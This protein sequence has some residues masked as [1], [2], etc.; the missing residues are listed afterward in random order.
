MSLAVWAS[1]NS[2]LRLVKVKTKLEKAW[3]GEASW[4]RLLRPLSLIFGWVSQSRR[5]RDQRQAQ[6]AKVP[7][8]VVG[9]ISV[10][11][12]GKTP[13]LIA[14]IRLC[15]QEGLRVGVISRGYG[16]VADNY[17]LSVTHATDPALCGDEP[18]MIVR[19]T[20]VSL[21]VDP[22]RVSAVNALLALEPLDL[23]LSD[24]G[25]QHYR[26]A[27]QLEIAVVD[28]TRGLGNGQL[29]PEGPL[30]EGPERLSQVDFVA[31]NGE[32]GFDYPDA[33]HYHLAPVALR[34]LQSG[35]IR[36]PQ[37]AAVLTP[38]VNALAAIGNPERFFETLNGLGFEVY[39]VAL[40]DHAAI[41][42]QRLAELSHETLVMTEK[43]A[44]KCGPAVNA[45]CWVLS[46]EARLDQRSEERLKAALLSLVAAHNGERN[47]S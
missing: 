46:V 16:G 1:V 40:P 21:V 37:Q 23:I 43:D 22:D 24:D 15:Q 27:R 45:N 9:N 29:L 41:D 36:E 14:M 28:A 19:Q 3:Y 20:G 35:E 42:P 11:G 44:V 4:V 8:V 39:G 18:A 25:L 5:S 7:V 12:T 2:V 13:L 38:S 30:R 47:G 6:P 34:N 10:G 26:L 17:P 33:L 32:G 31:I